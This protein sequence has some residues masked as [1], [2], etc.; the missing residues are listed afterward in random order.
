MPWLKKGG[1]RD[2]MAY[3]KHWMPW[4][5]EELT[6]RGMKTEMPLM[7]SPWKPNYNAF[8][9]EFEKH[10]VT[11][12]TILVGHS[13]GCAFLVRWLGETKRKAGKLILV[14]PWK[15]AEKGDRYREAFYGYPIDRAIRSRVKSIVMFTSDNESRAGKESLRLFHD[16]LGG[17]VIALK[18]HGHYTMDD[19]GTSEFPELLKEVVSEP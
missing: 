17:K 7:P 3:A 18:S 16:A 6:A 19:M 2:G 5:R 15:M 8:K 1:N 12:S 4:L 10:K 11:D 13:C 14:A 9:K